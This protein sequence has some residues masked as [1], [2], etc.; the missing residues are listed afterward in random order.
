M[1]TKQRIE[2]MQRLQNCEIEN[3]AKNGMKVKNE[4]LQKMKTMQYKM[5]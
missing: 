3:N 4:K 1:Q 2:R 5:E